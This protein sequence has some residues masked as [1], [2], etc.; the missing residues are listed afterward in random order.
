MSMDGNALGDA[1]K[2][3]CDALTPEQKRDR[4]EV[5]HALGTAI[6]TYLQANA[7]VN[8]LATGVQGGAGTAPVTGTVS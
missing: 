3:A 5:F 7:T 1:M 4:T 8:G 6:V 2:A